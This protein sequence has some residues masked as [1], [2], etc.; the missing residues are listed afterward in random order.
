MKVASPKQIGFIIGLGKKHGMTYSSEDFKDEKG[1][2]NITY[3]DAHNLII[4]LQ[5]SSDPADLMRKKII[6]MARTM[7]WY[8]AGTEKADIDRIDNWCIKYGQ[9]HKRLND[10]THDE[11]TKLVTQFQN[12]LLNSYLKNKAKS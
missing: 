9:F 6:S 3:Q 5:G 10:H 1:R 2:I 7:R 12:G 8:V 11:L 4:Q